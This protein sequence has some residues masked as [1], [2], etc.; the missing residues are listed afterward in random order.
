MPDYSP[1]RLLDDAPEAFVSTTI[2]SR[3]VS[4]RLRTGRLRKLASRLYTTNMADAPETVVR[5]NL[6]GIVAGYFPGALIADRTAL[7][8]EPAPDGSVC[9]VTRRGSTIHLPGITLR[10]R[11]GAGTLPTDRPFLHGL[12]LSSTA[13]AYLDNLRPSRARAG[14]LRRTL[15]REE[16]ETRL[17]DLVRRAG[18][19]AANRL[20]DDARAIA[21]ELDRGAELATL[22]ML[23]SSL[24]GTHAGRLATPMARA[25]QRGRPYDAHRIEQFGTLHA[26]L[27]SEPPTMRTTVPRDGAQRAV[28]SFFEAYFS[29]YIEGTEFSVEEAAE[30][31]FQ[32][33]I[34]ADRPADAHD[35]EGTWRLT[36]DPDEMQRLPK[37]SSELLEILRHRHSTVLGSRPEVLPGQF[38]RKPNQSGGNVFVMPED[39]VG[40]LEQAFPLYRGL[41]TAFQRGVFLLFLV[42][43]VHPFA[44]GNGRVARLM[45]NA[46]LAH[47]GEERI[48]IPTVYRGNYLAALRAMSHNNVT[49]PLIRSLDYAQRWTSAIRWRNLADAT[50]QLTK[51]NAFL[52][53]EVAENQGQRL[54]MPESTDG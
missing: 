32:G 16:V 7:E 45:M 33:R 1:A 35:I 12:F 2:V 11:R 30:I 22:S 28:L 40:T 31:V 44:D 39:V 13:R 24:A 25:R 49:E 26:A 17:D 48:V 10:P 54:R 23:V 21:A 19:G 5:R 43:E 42:S 52:E 37:D 34:P 8:N 6:W 15:T 53:S 51:C 47:R 4:R 29:N 18:A 36:S 3:E 20:R 14:R 41:E 9:L 27:R 38:K 50:H 46:E